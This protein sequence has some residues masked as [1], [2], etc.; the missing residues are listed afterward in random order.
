MIFT[1][2][3]MKKGKK[4][5]LIDTAKIQLEKKFKTDLSA[6]MEKGIEAADIQ[7]LAKIRDNIFEIESLDEVKEI[8]G[9]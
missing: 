9:V 1:Q 6:K 3:A 7:D 4:E 5:V 8:L 2:E